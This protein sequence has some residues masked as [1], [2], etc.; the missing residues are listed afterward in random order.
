MTVDQRAQKH[1][2]AT[3]TDTL[4]APPAARLDA[5]DGPT[6]VA[7]VTVRG[8]AW[9]IAHVVA[10]IGDQVG[11]IDAVAE[12]IDGAACTAVRLAGGARVQV[13]ATAPSNLLATSPD[14]FMINVVMD[15]LDSLTPDQLDALRSLVGRVPLT[16]TEIADLR[17][18][19]PLTVDMPAHLPPGCLADCAPVLAIHHMTDFLTM[20]ESIM[21]MGVPADAITVIDKGYRYRLRGRVDAH[22]REL[23]VRVW[24]WTQVSHALVDHVHR[25]E[26]M[27]RKGLLV[28]DGGYLLPV[29]L[30]QHPDL[31]AAF[32]GL[33]E[34]TM[35][36]IMRL[37]R[38]A[39]LPL[40]VFSVAQSRLKATIE[41]YGIADAAVRNLVNLLP[42]EKFEGQP[43]LVCGFGNI[44]EQVAELL[45]VRRMQVAVYDRAIVRLI[46]AHERGFV[47]D[48]SLSR[49]LAAHAPMLI[50]GTTGRACLRGEHAAALV[51]DCYL[52][53]TTSRAGEFALD[54]LAEQAIGS[55]AAGVLGFRLHL[56][57][58][59]TVTVVADGFPINFH[60]AESLPNKYS[61]LV[62]AAL[63]VGMAT[64]SG[65]KHGFAPG[66]DVA[67]T[68][69][70]LES[71]GLLE[72][73][74]DRFGPRRAR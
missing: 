57:S 40:P 21:R 10:S 27:G 44:G 70:V 16:G 63:L 59:V 41:S 12:R 53:S 19:M 1:N 52:V 67:R 62:L 9:E 26:A 29:L 46:A 36:G 43:A 47:T 51:R 25:A 73:Y 45:R 7:S 20:I 32:A 30:D 34:Q 72:R 56:P 13:A 55:S 6:A 69:A 18:Q 24:P 48:R 15:G 71:C 23:G 38:F 50:V 64:L 35:S 4:P 66:H 14:T 22:L 68:D 2:G 3:A 74:Y 5:G 39:M 11:A 37:E 31:V 33:V 42:Q 28:D 65:R 17:S 60:H 49:L 8:T 54:E 61:D 58:D